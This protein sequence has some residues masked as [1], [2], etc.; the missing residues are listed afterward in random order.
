MKLQYLEWELKHRLLECL[1]LRAALGCGP[2]DAV[3]TRRLELVD[4]KSKQISKVMKRDINVH[5][6]T[7]DV[8]P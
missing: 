8:V 7:N 3:V 2:S 5:G 4:V 1:A 6:A